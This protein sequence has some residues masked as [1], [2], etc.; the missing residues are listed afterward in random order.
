[1]VCIRQD[2][3]EATPS[4][5]TCERDAI[6]IENVA[7]TASVSAVLKAEARFAGL[8]FTDGW[9][10]DDFYVRSVR[11]KNGFFFAENM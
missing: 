8:K 2:E 7:M 6:E 5:E 9:H 3:P 1:M 11:T 4:T 10:C